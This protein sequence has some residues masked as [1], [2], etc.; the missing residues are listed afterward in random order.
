MQIYDQTCIIDFC[1]SV[2]EGPIFHGMVWFWWHLQQQIMIH[3]SKS[4]SW[5]SIHAG[6]WVSLISCF[7]MARSSSALAFKAWPHAA[8]PEPLLLLPCFKFSM[9][10]INF[11]LFIYQGHAG[12]NRAQRGTSSAFSSFLVSI[13][14]VPA[15]ISSVLAAAKAFGHRKRFASSGGL[16]K[17]NLRKSLKQLNCFNSKL[18]SLAKKNPQKNVWL[19]ALST[20]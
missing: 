19:P 14:L 16:C 18:P 7:L 17:K 2:L 20:S 15:L 4:S 6:A 9:V 11:A 1:Q 5:P 13:C 10:S 3:L 8:N 12:K